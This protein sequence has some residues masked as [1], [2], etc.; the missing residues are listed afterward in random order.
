MQYILCF[1]YYC[2]KIV[3]HNTVSRYT[4]GTYVLIK[5]RLY[6]VRSKFRGNKF[7]RTA[8]KSYTHIY[9]FALL[10]Y[11]IFMEIK[12]RPVACEGSRMQLFL[13]AVASRLDAVVACINV[14]H[15]MK[16][17]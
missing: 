16:N 2:K 10:P 11:K 12:H 4:K 5:I 15:P 1:T 9:I 8:E 6:C 17:Q 14:L 7:S 3:Q 13:I